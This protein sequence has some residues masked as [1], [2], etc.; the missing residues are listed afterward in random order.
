MAFVKHRTIL[1]IWLDVIFAIFVREI[2]SKFSDK[3]GISWA[4]AQPV[5]FIF[6]LSYMRSSIE[7]G[8]TH[9][10]PTFVFMVYGMICIQLFLTTLTSTSGSIKKNKQLFSFRQVQPI[11]SVIAVALFELVNK[12]VVISVLALIMYFIKIEISIYDP[13]RILIYL[14]SIWLIALSTGMLFALARAFIP[15]VDKVRTMLQRPLFFISGVFFS[16][17]D[18]PENIWIYLQWNPVLHAI[19]L[20][21]LAAYPIYGAVGVSELYLF[22]FTLTITFFSLCCYTLSWKQAISR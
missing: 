20:S 22:L 2:K 7:G 17:Q 5:S 4:V 8:E 18:L 10:I 12:V 19:E 11:A 3:L 15:E 1:Q 9:S 21:R 13:L 6:V 14:I 16:L